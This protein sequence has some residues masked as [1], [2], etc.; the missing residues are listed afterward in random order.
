MGLT[1]G[2]GSGKSTVL[3]MFRKKGAVVLDADAVVHEA[4]NKTAVLG[5]IKKIFG[6]DVVKGY[7]LD[8][9]KLADI[10]FS[11]VGKRKKLEKILHPLVRKKMRAVLSRCRAKVAICDVPLLFET[12]WDKKFKKIIVVDAP[13]MVRLRR[14]KKKGYSAEES[15]RRIAAQWP[16]AKK[17]KRADFVVNNASTIKNTK[18]Q[19]DLIWEN[20]LNKS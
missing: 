9:K 15:S 12:G 5:K 13:L 8:R 2:L 4:Y 16:I 20:I 7:R 11:S 18:A 17:I 3:E 10:V 6:P 1:G 19:V 14:L